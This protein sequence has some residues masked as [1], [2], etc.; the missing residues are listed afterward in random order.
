MRDFMR[1]FSSPSHGSQPVLS[2]FEDCTVTSVSPLRIR[3]DGSVDDLPFEPD[4]MVPAA[5][6]AVND[7]VRV[8]VK[9]GRVVIV[10]RAGGV[11]R[12]ATP[13][14][15]DDIATK[16]FVEAGLRL[17][18]IV[19]FTTSGTFTKA[20]YPG[21]RAL[22]VK[23]QAGGGAGGAAS[24]AGPTMYS[25]GAGGGGGGYAE[26]LITNMS[27]VPSSVP[28]TVGAGGGPTNGT[29]GTG[30]T[31]SFGSLATATGGTGGLSKPSNVYSP[32]VSPGAGGVGTVGDLLL[33]GGAGGIGAGSDT[34]G[35]G[36][37]GG[38][39]FMG[40][41][42]RGAASGAGGSSLAGEAG[43]NYGGGGSGAYTS[44]GGAA[45]QGGAGAPGIVIV[46]VYA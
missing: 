36:G 16:G 24:A 20:S 13:V 25:V 39:S 22:R 46:E 12:A 4:T 1:A 35:S 14:S 3:F 33:S 44:T 34:L 27:T 5:A 29:G 21:A 9:G 42:G 32:Y 45:K 41:G 30:G 26:R 11:T 17:I 31:S 10:G 2:R 37:S 8:E 6:L 38:S 23:V 19:Y 15:A 18:T 28:V 40:G 7:R 43:G